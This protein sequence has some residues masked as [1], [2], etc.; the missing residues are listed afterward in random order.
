MNKPINTEALE[1]MPFV[2]V[3]RVLHACG[4]QVVTHDNGRLAVMDSDPAAQRDAGLDL[5][6]RIHN[7]C[8]AGERTGCVSVDA[9][10]HAIE[11]YQREAFAE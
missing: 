4:M 3:V 6:D 2:E 11:Q 1:S 5:A 10:R 9:L 8:N 7:L